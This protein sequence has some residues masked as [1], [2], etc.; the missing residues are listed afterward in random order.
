M[1]NKSNI[2][3]WELPGYSAIESVKAELDVNAP[4]YNIMGQ[5]MNANNLPAGVYI[6]NGKKF[7]IK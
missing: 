4:V 5:K 1:A 7:V 3:Y 2:V 6:Q